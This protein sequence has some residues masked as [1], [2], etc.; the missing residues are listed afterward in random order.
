MTTLKIIG[1][2]L[3]VIVILFLLYVL[4]LTGYYVYKSTAQILKGE[5]KDDG[6][7]EP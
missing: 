3:S 5:E 4:V 2:I 7:D 1:V 6:K